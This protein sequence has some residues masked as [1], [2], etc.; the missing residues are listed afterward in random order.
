VGLTPIKGLRHPD[1]TIAKL[2]SKVINYAV[3]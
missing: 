2:A 3:V 1:L